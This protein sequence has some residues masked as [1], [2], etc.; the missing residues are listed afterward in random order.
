MGD[1]SARRR[2]F[3]G[4]LGGLHA[5]YS[6]LRTL[7]AARAL[8]RPAPPLR[9]D[10]RRYGRLRRALLLAGIG[11]STAAL[12]AVSLGT[13]PARLERALGATRLPAPARRAAFV[14]V[15]M[16][17]DAL[18]ALPVQFI[19]DHELE[20]RYGLGTQSAR[21]WLRDQAAGLGL[22]LLL[23]APLGALAWAAVARWPRRWPWA[24]S[25][26]GFPLLAA[27]NLA[28]PLWIAPVFNRFVPYDGPLAGRLRAL[29][30]NAGVGGV[31]IFSVDMS[32]RTAKANAYVTGIFGSHRIVIGDTLL[33]HFEP[34]EVLFIVAH[35]I[36]HYVHGDV[37]RG[38]AGG[39]LCAAIVM[40]GATAL[41]GTQGSADAT[42]ALRLLLCASLLSY[43]AAPIMAALS[44]NRE[45]SADRYAL[46]MTA[47]PRAGAAA[48][49]RLAA[50]NLAETEQPVWMELLFATHPSL[51]ARIASLRAVS[52]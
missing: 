14:A 44:R 10:A 40:H 12:A 51:R 24:A 7:Q 30:R 16:A 32:R 9:A 35:E 6:A 36:G 5:G 4:L 43:A 29:A 15:V 3:I 37:W 52:P 18:S 31:D 50:R 27:A 26:A 38:V 48:F 20:R 45:W 34:D 46:R 19:E 17:G 23:G 25:V 8:W 2:F 11:R 42:R 28:L 49:E 41:A 21:G 47:N 33:A 22:S 1:H 13:L 39:G